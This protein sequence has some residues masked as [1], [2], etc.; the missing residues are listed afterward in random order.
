MLE[1]D[2]IA[3]VDASY[4]TPHQAHVV[5]RRRIGTAPH[6]QWLY[7][8]LTSGEVPATKLGREWR[9]PPQAVDVIVEL[10]LAACG[11]AA[12]PRTDTAA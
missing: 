3:T 7:A 2:L 4:L 8:R 9:L 5:T 12:P 11:R 6:P 10:W 1:L